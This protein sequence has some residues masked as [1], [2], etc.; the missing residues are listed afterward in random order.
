MT[1]TDAP[2]NARLARPG[3]S[4][5][6]DGVTAATEAV[7]AALAGTEPT[8]ADLVVLLASARYDAVALH[9]AA[10]DAAAPA[11]VVGCTTSGAFTGDEQIPSGCVALLLSGDDLTFGVGV[12][13]RLGDELADR[14]AAA[15]RSARADAGARR[16]H[17]AV[18]LFSDGLAGDQREILRGAY[19]VTGARVPIVGGAAGDD[20]QLEATR[21]F[22]PDGVLDNGL[23]AVWIESE[24]PVAVTVEHGWR[25][26]GRPVTIT[27][28][29]G[30][31]ILELDGCP[32]VSTYEQVIGRQLTR[33]SNGVA[34]ESMHHPLGVPNPDGRFDVRHVMT[35][36][37]QGLVMFGQVPEQS[38]VQIMESDPENLIDG[39]RLAGAEAALQLERSARAALAFSCVA[40]VE[41][42]GA[43]LDEEARTVSAALGGVPLAGF[44]TYGEFARVAGSTGF[45]NATVTVL[46]L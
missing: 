11:R 23:V 44:F 22:T 34:A 7:A 35:T 41:A 10:R 14:T 9:A 12:A 19:E 46:A 31:T 29:A 13:Q 18:L 42:L 43:R 1:A 27:R 5:H 36:A 25:P 33:R 21:Q 3:V 45:H 39:A 6:V 15:V 16:E 20:L 38:L 40:R 17:R 4:H 24:S 37:G 28:T 32:A 8:S 2:T 26:I 30:N